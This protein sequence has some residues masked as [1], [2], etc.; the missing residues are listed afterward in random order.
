MH[1]TRVEAGRFMGNTLGRLACAVC[2]TVLFV[3]CATAGGGN[4]RSMFM[5]PAVATQGSITRTNFWSMDLAM[6][7]GV[8]TRGIWQV[9]YTVERPEQQLEEIPVFWPFPANDT[10]APKTRSRLGGLIEVE[11]T[12]AGETYN[13]WMIHSHT[14]RWTNPEGR[15]IVSLTNTSDK[16]A[17]VSN[18]K[19]ETADVP[20]VE[21]AS[22]N[23]G[24]TVGPG[25]TLQF[26]LFRVRFSDVPQDLDGAFTVPFRF[27]DMPIALN[28]DGSI[29]EISLYEDSFELIRKPSTYTSEMSLTPVHKAKA[30]LKGSDGQPHYRSDITYGQY[31]TTEYFDPI[32]LHF[33]IEIDGEPLVANEPLQ[34]AT[35]AD[36]SATYDYGTL[37]RGFPGGAPATV[38]VLEG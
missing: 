13:Y 2:A 10:G 19:I 29:R 9:S 24:R 3:S 26:E 30:F 5:P 18:M 34:W 7:S 11:Q 31:H 25:K 37:Q 8:R 4:S 14:V 22:R 38:V 27:V 20:G 17:D 1:A 36:K 33:P 12:A 28:P 21:L 23:A 32:D 35:P 6:E 15:I 16:T